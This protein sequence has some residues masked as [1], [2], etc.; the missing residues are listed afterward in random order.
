V[1]ASASF[2]DFDRAKLMGRRPLISKYRNLL[3]Y[4][5]GVRLTDAI[6]VQTEDQVAPCEAKF[7]RRPTV[8][9]SLQPLEEP[10]QEPA[11]AFIWVGRLVSYKRPL[12]YLALAQALP[13]AKFWMIGVPTS[14][15]ENDRLMVDELLTES[16]KLQNFELLGARPRNEVGAL[17]GR[18][19]AAV[20]TSEFEG[21]P[22]A[23]LEAWSRGVPAL[24]LNHDPG[25]VVETFGLGGFARG[26]RDELVELA[27]RQWLGRN[28]RVELKTRCRNYIHSHHSPD[29]IAQQWA[30]IIRDP[31]RSID[32]LALSDKEVEC[33]T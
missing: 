10:Q 20:N 14:S 13:Q 16:Q 23:L 1:F 24:V 30:G 32:Q 18:A 19:V 4:E 3:I 15:D 28:D 11:E 6:I 29:V 7:G 8:I 22:N 5:L 31:G 26:S 17:L 21:M 9:K 2:V 25:G 27:H 12:E 33:V